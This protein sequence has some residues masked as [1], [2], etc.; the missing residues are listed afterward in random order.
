IWRLSSRFRLAHG[1]KRQRRGRTDSG[2]PGAK[3]GALPPTELQASLPNLLAL[4]DRTDL[5]PGGRVVYLN[6]S[7][8]LR[9]HGYRAPDHLDPCL[10]PGARAGLAAQH[11]RLD[12]LQETLLGP[13]A[14]HLR[15]PEMRYLRGHRQRRRIEGAS[16]LGLAG[17]R[18][19]HAA[20]SLDRRRQNLVQE[21]RLR[22]LAHQRRWESMARCRYRPFFD[23]ALPHESCI[24][25]AVVPGRLR[26]GVVPG[27]V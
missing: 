25:A 5:P 14:A 17:V 1:T 12:D 10:W 9:D 23:P 2:E 26:I 6:G 24:L 7:T 16:C 22:G 27:P 15:L 3:R 19:P 11:G 21:V 20:P 8:A 18:G 4:Q 13:G